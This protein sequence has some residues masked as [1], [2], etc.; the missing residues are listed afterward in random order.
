[1]SSQRGKHMFEESGFL[2]QEELEKYVSGN[3]TREE[4]YVIEQKISANQLN[5][6]A[7]EGFEHN[8]NALPN[9][10]KYKQQF[11]DSTSTTPNW[12]KAP[13]I[14]PALAILVGFTIAT[15]V[16]VDYLQRRHE[17]AK[18]AAVKPMQEP[19][20]YIEQPYLNDFEEDQQEIVSAA[21]IDEAK[22]I[23][24]KVTL[25]N[26]VE[27]KASVIPA[28]DEKE[29]KPEKKQFEGEIT[30][31]ETEH[32]T[33]HVPEQKVRKSSSMSNVVVKYYHELKTVD[34][35]K[36]YGQMVSA[37]GFDLSGV[38]AKYEYRMNNDEWNRY[39][40]NT[41]RVT[42]GKYLGDAMEKF[43]NNQYKEALQ[44]YRVV[45]EQ[46][47]E[48]QNALFYGG[49]CYYNIGKP[50]KAIQFFLQIEK[51]YINT[52]YEE[53]KWY[54]AL[55]YEQLNETE[56]LKATLEEIIDENGFY[57]KKAS[58]KLGK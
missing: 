49:L 6:E 15:L 4:Q 14:V 58:Q 12:L 11:L 50:E 8:P 20:K 24:Y 32:V 52:F 36:F 18:E 22:Q 40:P 34:Y 17:P 51:S 46:F 55:S 5:T 56:K 53:A 2:S 35:S 1:M 26:Q 19:E 54:K 7:I 28:S 41:T 27:Q 42:Y 39:G 13:V 44:D 38:E 43:A 23:S 21:E 30:A 31:L 47:P 25:D 3:V 57:A 10:D 16:T 48:D 37:P 9:I 29:A 33:A 45:L